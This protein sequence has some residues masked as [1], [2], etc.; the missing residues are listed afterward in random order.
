MAAVCIP[1]VRDACDFFNFVFCEVKRASLDC[2]VNSRRKAVV[3]SLIKIRRSLV[4]TLHHVRHGNSKSE[5]REQNIDIDI[6][7]WKSLQNNYLIYNWVS[8][9]F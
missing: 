2:P 1:V 9:S 3:F 7:R 5:V 4:E 8:L 6:D